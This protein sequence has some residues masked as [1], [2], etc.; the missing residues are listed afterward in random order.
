M[1]WQEQNGRLTKVEEKGSIA[2]LYDHINSMSKKFLQHCHIKRLQ[3]KQYEA[4]KEIAMKTNSKVAVLQMDFAENYSCIAQDEVQSTHW[5]QTQ[6]TLFTTVAWVSGV[7]RSHVVISDY[8]HRTKTAVV[9][10]LDALLASLPSQAEEIRIWTDGP[11]SQFKIKFVMQGMKMLADK[12]GLSLSWNFFAT[13]HGKG[14]VDGIGGCLKRIATDRVKTR[15]STINSA[16]DFYQAVTGSSVNT[17]LITS[18]EVQQHEMLLGLPELFAS[19]ASIKGIL[20]FHWIGLTDGDISTRRYSS[21]RESANSHDDSNAVTASPDSSV[22]NDIAEVIEGQWYAV[23]WEASDYW[24]IGR[25]TKVTK[26]LVTLEFVHQMAPDVNTFKSTTDVDSVP[27][28]DVFLHIDPPMPVSSS[29]CSSFRLQDEDF[30]RVKD[31]F[32]EFCAL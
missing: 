15:Q 32:K 20:D 6:V 17:T 13:S 16:A 31:S 21:E 14:P 25:A 26:N 23:F 12:F 9:V 10:F 2:D 3:A 11:S 18:E 30:Q 27:L 4:D 1:K 5:N 24:F 29:R 8:M 19:A 7:V 28:S 22:Q